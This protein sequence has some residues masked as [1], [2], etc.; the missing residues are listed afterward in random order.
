MLRRPPGEGR[1]VAEQQRNSKVFLTLAGLLLTSWLPLADAQ[2]QHSLRHQQP[3]VANILR[4]QDDDLQGHQE[5][6]FESER[7]IGKLPAT[8]SQTSTARKSTFDSIDGLQNAVT[9]IRNH[10]GNSNQFRS[11]P[12]HHKDHKNTNTEPYDASALATVALEHHSVRAPK[13]PR[14]LSSVLAGAG[15]S[16]PQSAR[17][18]ERWEVED[19]VLLAT[20][21]GHIYAVNKESGEERWR[22][23]SEYPAVETIH[24]R[25]NKSSGDDDYHPIHDYIWAVEPTQDG[26]VYVYKS[27][28]VGAGLTSTGWTMKKIVE[29]LSGRAQTDPPVV[30]TGDKKTE[31][32][33]VDA[34]T[35]R[36]KKWFGGQMGH[37]VDQTCSRPNDLVDMDNGECSNTGTIALVRTEYTVSIHREDDGRLLA[38]LKYREW[39]P[40]TFD[41]DL[42]QQYQKTQLSEYYTSRHDGTLYAL[43]SEMDGYPGKALRLSVP[44]ARVFDVRRPRDVPKG[45][46]P[47]LVLLPQPT[48]PFSD[49]AQA[50]SRSSSIFLNQTWSGSWYAMSGLSYPLMVDAPAAQVSRDRISWD[51]D[52]ISDEAYVGRVL[53]GNHVLGNVP[54]DVDHL[55]GTQLPPMLPLLGLPM[56]DTDDDENDSVQALVLNAEYDLSIVEKVLTLPETT[57]AYVKEF[58]FNPVF[59]VM[60]AAGLIYYLKALKAGQQATGR[61]IS[62]GLSPSLRPPLLNKVNDASPMRGDL[63]SAADEAIVNNVPGLSLEDPVADKQT[64][65]VAAA[66]EAARIELPTAEPQV[67]GI[68][69]PEKKDKMPRKRGTRGGKK[70]KKKSKQDPSQSQ[71]DKVTPSD[72]G[73][74]SDQIIKI[75]NLGKEPGLQPNVKT[76]P[77]DP[78]D[79]SSGFVING[80]QVNT[81]EQL[82]T[83]SNGTLVF[84]GKFHGRSV[85]VK[86]MLGAFY[87]IASQETKLLLESDTHQNVIQYFAL[88]EDRTFLY[89]AL[90]RCDASLSDIVEKPHMHRSLAQA[91]ERDIPNVLLQIA[92]GLSHL[93]SLRIVHR[94]LKPQN[95][96]VTM[97]KEGKPRLVVSDFGLCKKLDGIQ[98]SFGATT[99]HA[100]GTSGWRAPELLL[101]D[102]ARD[103]ST[104][105]ASSHS[106]S[107][108]SQLVS[109]DV[110]PNRRATRAIDIFSLGL[111]FFYVLTK[112]LHPFDCGDRYMREVNI[113]KGQSNLE[114]LDVLGDFAFEAKDLI[115]SM[116]SLDPRSRPT[117]VEVMAHPFFWGPKK[118]LTFLCDISD[119]FEKEQRDPPS[120]A[121]Q[122]LESYARVVT[123]GDFLK[124]LTKEFVDSLG[125]QRK[126]TGSRLLDLLRALRNKWNHREDMTDALKKSVGITYEDYLGYWTRRFPNLLVICSEI[127]Y[128]LGLQDAVRFKE[129]FEPMRP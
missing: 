38:T 82:G 129:Y 13:S 75:M 26:P 6:P 96:L 71:D 68:D 46:N 16:S 33:T 118:R 89:I 56:S 83:G 72:D 36:I 8:I 69:S 97:T 12:N 61:G 85:A 47:E 37:A 41:S 5:S 54:E 127:I 88:H 99:A 117:T 113:R 76:I 126:Y 39:A 49:S 93:H 119:H 44:V 58:F 43:S 22:L 51:G 32:V 107:E 27:S 122:T 124:V 7:V 64:P 3:P 94:D 70:H 115:R 55:Y 35:G 50:R 63:G 84:S 66:E 81:D 123:H 4:K 112:G 15:L 57:A 53:A 106:H 102:D 95:I 52:R 40:N 62:S 17:S 80:L 42:H 91:G 79:L 101:D 77:G 30:Y 24:N 2:P 90:E 67:V 31:V 92:N 73:P 9:T 65:A 60:L 78:E 25:P 104:S 128:D 28:G 116:L 86:R 125:K 111:V 11:R 108:S 98:S 14:Q 103:M 34:A 110:M 74:S 1:L 100:A 19:F 20:V 87:D 120:E 21:D 114:P 59:Y 121:L 18:L 48:P 10:D 29:E 109:S 105:M 23:D 45:S